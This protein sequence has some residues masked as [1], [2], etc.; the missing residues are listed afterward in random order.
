MLHT[1]F[2]SSDFFF[3]VTEIFLQI[4]ISVFSESFHTKFGSDRHNSFCLNFCMYTTLD[5]GQEMTL[6]FN[7]HIYSYIQLDVCS[8]YLSDHWLQ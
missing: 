4:F 5:K 2:R 6:T 1:K 7:S 3:L 8:Y